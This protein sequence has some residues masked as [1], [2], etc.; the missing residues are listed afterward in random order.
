MHSSHHEALF[1]TVDIYNVYCRN[2]EYIFYGVKSRLWSY[3]KSHEHFYEESLYRRGDAVI[4]TVIE[5]FFESSPQLVLQIY[6]ILTE[7][8]HDRQINS[9]YIINLFS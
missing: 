9:K 2:V 1:Y 5:I 6:I 8:Y 3:S 7:T 4:L